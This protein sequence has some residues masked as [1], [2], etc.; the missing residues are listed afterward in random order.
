MFHPVADFGS[1]G[2]FRIEWRISDR[3]TAFSA[4][5]DLGMSS[6]DRVVASS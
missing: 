6:L 1:S 3:V 5:T 2:G 4:V